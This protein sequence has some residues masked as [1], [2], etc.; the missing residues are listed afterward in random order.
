MRPHLRQSVVTREWVLFATDR[1][2]R[3]DD[4][5]THGRQLT[6]QRPRTRDDCPFCPGH[7]DRVSPETMR[8]E[9]PDGSWVVKACPNLY[10][11]IQ[12]GDGRP[13]RMGETFHR[14]MD[15][16]GSH[17][18]VLESERH[19]MTLALQSV[20]EV[21]AVLKVW[22]SRYRALLHRPETEHVTVFK[23]HGPSAGT[24]L[25]HPHSQIVSLPVTPWQV[26]S[27]MEEALRFHNDHG[28]CLFC[29]MIRQERE[30]RDRILVDDG[31]FVAF[32]PFAAYSPFSIWLF[33]QRHM[34]CFASVRDTELDS[35]AHVLHETMGRLYYGLGDPDYNIVIRAAGRDCL[36]VPFFHWYLAIVPRLGRAAGFELG[37]GMFINTSLPEEDAAFLRGVPLTPNLDATPT[38][39]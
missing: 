25:E 38:S 22:R 4:W 35:L 8:V 1:R 33:P 19:D 23:N 2:R 15:G 31:T 21:R 12:P 17:E 36:A 32:V 7:P 9:A 37:T 3:P 28:E 16:V 13:E 24:S 5:A 18:V 29:R 34:S 10:P 39:G 20:D 26:R 30:D 14:T 6:S 27:R 11:A